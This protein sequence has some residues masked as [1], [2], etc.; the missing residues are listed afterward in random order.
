MATSRILGPDGQPI[1]MPD[2]Q[3]PQTARLAHLQRELNIP[4]LMI[5]HDD[6]DLRSLADEVVHL[7]AGRVVTAADA[8]EA[9]A[10]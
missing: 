8:I 9:V 7:S 10:A 1:K 3:E 6:D 2:L 4:M 5:T